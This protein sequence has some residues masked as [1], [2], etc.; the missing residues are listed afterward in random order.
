MAH[1]VELEI[2]ECDLLHLAIGRMIVDPVLVATE[3]VARVQHRR[4]LVAGAGE[5]VELAAG[6][7]AHALEMRLQ[8]RARIWRETEP[9]QVADAAID[10][11]E[12]ETGAVRRHVP[13]RI[14]FRL[15]R[16]D[17][18]ARNGVAVHWAVPPRVCLDALPEGFPSR[19]AL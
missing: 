2:A 18:A 12:V 7:F 9:E 6:Q 3:A 5:C 1:G 11:K 4:M 16:D 17:I 10:G 19:P 15:G 14:V 13:R 8:R